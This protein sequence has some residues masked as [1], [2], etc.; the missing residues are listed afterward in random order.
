MGIP[1]LRH[2]LGG[3]DSA[4]ELP[5]LFK[6]KALK[7]VDDLK[8]KN[9]A[10]SKGDAKKVLE[11]AKTAAKEATKEDLRLGGDGSKKLG[12]W[13]APEEVNG[14]MKAVSAALTI[15]V[16]RFPEVGICVLAPTK[17]GEAE[18]KVATVAQ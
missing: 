18:Q 12:V 1:E 5:L 3:E 4:A 2:R 7:D 17:S 10:H 13:V 15:L 6:R 8:L 9:L 16:E 14:D 11:A